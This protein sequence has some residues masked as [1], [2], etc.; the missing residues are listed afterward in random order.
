[1]LDSAAARAMLAFYSPVPA[2]APF[3]TGFDIPTTALRRIKGNKVSVRAYGDH[4]GLAT[5][6][7]SWALLMCLQ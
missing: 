6:P 2:Y 5:V 7:V 4:A 3:I 1:M